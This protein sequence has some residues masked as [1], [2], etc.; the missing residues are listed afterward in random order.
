M[1]L[2]QIESS[3]DLKQA[4]REWIEEALKKSVLTIKLALVARIA[5]G[6]V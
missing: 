5:V 1:A 2:L 6:S 3:V 4:H